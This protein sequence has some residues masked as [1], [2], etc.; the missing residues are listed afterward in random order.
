VTLAAIISMRELLVDGARYS[1]G[2]LPADVV[3]ELDARLAGLEHEL[4]P[5]R[6]RCDACGLTFR[7][8]G[9]RDAHLCSHL[10]AAA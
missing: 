7:W 9:L 6:F 2:S 10:E 4:A 3:A 5:P 1:D 8:P